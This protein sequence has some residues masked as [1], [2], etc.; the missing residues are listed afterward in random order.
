MA[1]EKAGQ[2]VVWRVC[3]LADW[4]VVW[5][6]DQKVIWKVGRWGE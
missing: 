3:Q 6:A 2:W 4:L 5:K 1:G